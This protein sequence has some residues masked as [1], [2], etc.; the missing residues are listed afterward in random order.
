MCT[1]HSRTKY[2]RNF[3]IMS[4][5]DLGAYWS[6]IAASTK[7]AFQGTPEEKSVTDVLFDSSPI[8][9]GD[10]RLNAIAALTYNSSHCDKIFR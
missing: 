8:P 5:D 1:Q 7:N 2:Y 4:A 3:A 10:Q 9:L 6:T